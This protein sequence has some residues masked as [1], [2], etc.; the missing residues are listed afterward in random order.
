MS[1]FKRPNSPNY[2]YEFEIAGHRVCR[3]A[4]TTSRR[5]AERIE[6]EQK[7]RVKADLTSGKLKPVP[8]TV[9]VEQFT[10]SQACGVYWMEKSPELKGKWAEDTKRYID[11]I[12]DSLPLT[13]LISAIGDKDI[14]QFVLRRKKH[15]ASDKG[16]RKGRPPA[17]NCAINRALAVFR[18]VLNHAAGKHE[19]TIKAI[20]WGSH[21]QNEPKERVR[22]LTADEMR[23]L[24]DHLP[25]HAR[26][27]VAW[28][29]YT[30]IRLTATYDLK[31]T[32][33]DFAKCEATIIK[34]GGHPQTVF[35]SGDAIALL[36]GLERDS[37][38]V[39]NGRNRRKIWEAALKKAGI[40]NFRWHDLRHTHATWLRQAGA[41]LEIVQRSLGHQSI[42]TT[43]RYAH[44][45]DSEMRSALQ[46]LPRLTPN[47]E[48]V[49]NVVPLKIKEK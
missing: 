33:I 9:M 30:G 35:L 20:D 49:T 24:L 42:K 26:V 4:K 3:S 41:A 6:R 48:Q 45:A 5:E 39:F 34:K 17:G 25:D 10:L 47:S 16:S 1:V 46:N 18:S 23:R 40:K 8:A 2:Y 11:Q 43:Q 38:H 19:Q 29:V 7:D 36:A 31:W 27:A 44:V 21:W 22:W 28:S 12:M 14:H 15:F 37:V 32:D 13:Q